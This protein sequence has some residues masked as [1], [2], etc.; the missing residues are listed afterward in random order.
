MNRYHFI[1]GDAR[2][3]LAK[4]RSMMALSLAIVLK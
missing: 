3:V 2:E 1:T 4:R